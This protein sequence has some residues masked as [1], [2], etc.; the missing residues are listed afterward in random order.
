MLG[1]R[2]K[3]HYKQQG[4]GPPLLI[5]HGLFG[6]LDNWQSFARELAGE[7][8]V[9]T[10]DLRNHGKSFHHP[11]ITYPLMADDVSQLI[12]AMGIAPCGIIGHSM[13]G[14]VAME[15]LTRN[16]DAVSRTMVLDIANRSYPRVHLPLLDAM[17]KLDLQKLEARGDIDRALSE[18]VPDPAV[19]RFLLKNVDREPSGRFVWKLNLDALYRNYDHIA[20]GVHFIHPLKKDICFVR[21][22]L[23]NYLGTEDMA[24]LK[25]IFPA[26][27]FA[28]IEGAGHW[29]HA[30][31]PQQLLEMVRSF[32]R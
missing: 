26:A 17:R 19:R 11:D 22:S 4:S 16:A 25:V 23:S 10:P 21:G 12:A 6:S 28:T 32:F 27:R 3:L 1:S 20:G 5:L 14:K 30:D 9:V 29:I 2:N 24:S 13:G 31:Q 7:F 15:L 8:T 18:T